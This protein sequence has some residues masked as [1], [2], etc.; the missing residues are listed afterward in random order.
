MLNITDILN[1]NGIPE[2]ALLISFDGV[3]MFPSIRNESGIKSVERLTY[4]IYSWSF[5]SIF[6]M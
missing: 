4:F 5:A 1:N 6:R 2:N 3:T